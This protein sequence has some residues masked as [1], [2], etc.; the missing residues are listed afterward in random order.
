M[1]VIKLSDDALVKEVYSIIFEAGQYLYKSFHLI[2][3]KSGYT[4]EN[5]KKDIKNNEVYLFKNQEK[6]VG[7]V[8]IS[9][10][11]SFF[12]DDKEALYFSKF[13]IRPEYMK[14][15]FGK[16]ILEFLKQE[17]RKRKKKYLRCDCYDQS[18]ETLLFYYRNGFYRSHKEKTKYFNVECLEYKI[19][20]RILVIGAGILQS[21]LIRKCKQLGYCVL[22]VDANPNAIGFKYADYKALIDI[23]DQEK[24]LEYTKRMR[25][26]GVITGATDYG[27]LT[28]SYIT[29]ELG[30]NGLNYNVAK[31][32]KNKFEVQNIL[33]NNG[34]VTDPSYE[35]SSI[36][37]LNF[38][39]NKIRYPVIIKPSD[40]SG[41][42]GVHKATSFSDI[43]KYIEEA[44]NNSLINKCIIEP[45]IE[46]KE[47]GAEFYVYNGVIYD[48]IT[49][50][51]KMTDYPFFA[52]LGHSYNMDKKI[53]NKIFQKG[54]QIIKTLGINFGAVNMDFI[55]NDKDV[56][57]VDI[58]CRMG[59]NLIGS[60]IIPM[61]TGVDYMEMI[62]NGALN[63]NIHF[64]KKFSKAVSS[65]LIV[66]PTGTVTKINRDEINNVD[67]LYKV[68]LCKVNDIVHSYRN[69]LDGCGYVICNGE[70]ILISENNVEKAL[71]KI[72]KSISVLGD[73]V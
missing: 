66:L 39:K 55:V 54:H 69:N 9:Q 48:L 10:F 51:K 44:I 46:G 68:I 34:I 29:Q 42:R 25:V 2:H 72:Q 38:I 24:C 26:D 28:T 37:E 4:L 30:L 19:K 14:K 43:E 47:Y 67:C 40:G 53:E 1:E 6:Y 61:S 22:A 3:W 64:E 60:H 33:Y 59:G 36:N 11:S 35:V 56:Y 32:V 49:L 41:S 70:N 18:K 27:V 8:I 13:A 15:G 12:D 31:L 73:S 16:Q 7:T 65:K 63:K 23:T 5:I 58:G 57:M 52:E 50:S 45:F 62:I 20:K 21:Y 71:E 17:S